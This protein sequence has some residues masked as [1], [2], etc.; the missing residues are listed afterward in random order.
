MSLLFWLAGIID[1][2][3]LPAEVPIRIV[4]S[5]RDSSEKRRVWNTGLQNLNE[6]GG[7]V[8]VCKCSC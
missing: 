8:A 4:I 7:D 6:S 1:T 5:T 2:W 3:A